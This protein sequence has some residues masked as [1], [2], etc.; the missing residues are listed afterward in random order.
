V[1][2]LA[3][4]HHLVENARPVTNSEDGQVSWSYRA[5]PE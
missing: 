3:P 1:C 5:N 4:T 2:T